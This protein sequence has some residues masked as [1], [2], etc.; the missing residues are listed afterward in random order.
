MRRPQPRLFVGF[1]I[2]E[3]KTQIR[4]AGIS[5]ASAARPFHRDRSRVSL[6]IESSQV[7]RLFLRP[8]SDRG[9]A[10]AGKVFV[11]RSLRTA[12]RT[13]AANYWRLPRE[14]HESTSDRSRKLQLS[15][16]FF[17]ELPP[18][19]TFVPIKAARLPAPLFQ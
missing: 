11:H 14:F 10:P 15:R 9:S 13:R 17:G 6:Q 4:L 16:Q 3:A 2:A 8:A 5:A 12:P 18:L 19:P 7:S 1:L